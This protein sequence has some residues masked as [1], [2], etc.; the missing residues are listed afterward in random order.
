MPSRIYNA[1][2]TVLVYC[3]TPDESLTFAKAQLIGSKNAMDCMT[4]L[5]CANMSGDDKC[6]LL[7]IG[8][9]KNLTVL[10]ELMLMNCLLFIMQIP[11]CG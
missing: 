2:K 1:D 9:S 3:A 4:V 10:R 8:K 7:N 6:P 11:M 5:C